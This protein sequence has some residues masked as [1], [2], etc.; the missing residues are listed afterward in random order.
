MS[1][2][3]PAAAFYATPAARA[4]FALLRP[5]DRWLPRAAAHVALRLFFTPLP[6][7][8]AA[9]ARPMPAAWQARRLPFEGGQLTVWEHRD[10]PPGAPRVLLVHGWAG[11]ARQLCVMG[12]ALLQTGRHPVLIDL[13]AHGRSDG[14]SS[15][16]AQWV[17]ALFVVAARLGPW[18]GVVAH[19]L[20]AVAVAHALA[21]GLPCE[22]LALVAAAPAPTLFMRWYAGA[23]G[24]GDTLADRMVALVERR[25]GIVLSEFEAPWF[26]RRLPQATLLVHDRGD[27]TAP[28]AVSQALARSLPRARLHATEGL[29]HR[30]VLGDAAVV[31]AMTAHLSTASEAG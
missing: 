25:E 7:K 14:W 18:E 9:R 20:G 21:R 30:R 23:I 11:D 4:L 17:R 15:N 2:T 10:A 8:L 29:G 1:D 16:L 6:T 31:A 12:E 13:P 28:F 19:S 22:R 27:R 5:L 24:V 3:N 26:G